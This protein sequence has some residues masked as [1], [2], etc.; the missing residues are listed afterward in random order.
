MNT[1]LFVRV[2]DCWRQ[3]CNSLGVR[4][5]APFTVYCDDATIRTAI[6]YLPDFG[7]MMGTIVDSGVAP[8][9]HGD[10][11][12]QK[13]AFEIKAYYSV[14]NAERFQDGNAE[15]II[16]CLTDWGFYPPRTPVFMR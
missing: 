16:E 11:R 14:I 9:F 2:A 3:R 12:I 15:R 8:G 13:Y 10:P 6:A 7:G 1:D 4:V 5:L